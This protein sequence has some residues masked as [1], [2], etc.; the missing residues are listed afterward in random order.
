[1][2]ASPSAPVPE[3]LHPGGHRRVGKRS[4]PPLVDKFPMGAVSWVQQLMPELLWIQLLNSAHG[5]SRGTELCFEL[6]RLGDSLRDGQDD[7]E[8]FVFA[9]AFEDLTTT[10]WC[11]APN[12]LG[13]QAVSDLR[14]AIRPLVA[15]IGGCPLAGLYLSPPGA[16][17]GDS[18][19][20]ENSVAAL[21]DRSSIPAT[22]AQGNALYAMFRTGRLS[23]TGGSGLAELRELEVYPSTDDSRKVASLVR[24]TLNAI[25]GAHRDAHVSG[26]SAAFW[27]GAYQLGDCL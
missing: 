23:V 21:L 20:L 14:S 4:I 3:A 18:A 13:E 19:V 17:P 22:R 9:S 27:R 8:I 15:L 2:T 26:W 24:A 6:A 10:E 1:M 7:L 5:W 16:E 11:S 12:E 25:Y